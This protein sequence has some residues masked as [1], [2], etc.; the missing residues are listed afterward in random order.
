[1]EKSRYCDKVGK[2]TKSEQNFQ[3]SFTVDGVEGLSQVNE[4]YVKVLVL[5]LTFI[6]NLPGHKDVRGSLICPEATL[7]FR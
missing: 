7:A 2:A 3:T 1:M 5:F 4:S 6:F